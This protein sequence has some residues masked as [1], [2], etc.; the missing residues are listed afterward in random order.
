MLCKVT[1]GADRIWRTIVMTISRSSKPDQT[2]ATPRPVLPPW[3]LAMMITSSETM[4]PA[5][6][7]ILAVRRRSD[8]LRIAIR[9]ASVKSATWA[10]AIHFLSTNADNRYEVIRSTSSS[11]YLRWKVAPGR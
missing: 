7:T 9:P 8:A 3:W 6:A 10:S 5:G 1:E 4:K 2:A 11:P